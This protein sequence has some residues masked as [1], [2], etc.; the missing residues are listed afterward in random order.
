MKKTIIRYFILILGA[1]I[2]AFAIEELL[3]PSQILDGGIVGVRIIISTLTAFPLSLFKL[4]SNF[5]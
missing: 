4:A 3:V 2:A 5:Y 1:V